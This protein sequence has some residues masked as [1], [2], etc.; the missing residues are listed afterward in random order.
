MPA[1]AAVTTTSVISY[2]AAPLATDALAT[3]APTAANNAA[4]KAAFKE[5]HIVD[6]GDL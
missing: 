5:I 1:V 4:L 6:T 3:P 2:L